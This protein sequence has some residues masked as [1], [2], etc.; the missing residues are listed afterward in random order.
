M[1]IGTV[2]EDWAVESMAGDIFLLGTHSWQIRRIEAGVVR[3]RDAGDAPPTVPFWLGEAPARTAEL[4]EEVSELRAPRRRASSPPAIP[5]AHAP[6]CST[7]AGIEH[8][9]RD[10]ARRLPGGRPRGARRDADAASSSCSSGS[11]TRP[12]ACSWSSTRPTAGASTGRSGWRCARS[13]AAR[14]TSSS[15]RPRPTTPSCCRSARTTASRSTRCRATC[16]SRGIED[17]LEHAILDAPMF[18]AR[19]RWNLNRS[20]IVLRFRGGRR[21]PPPIQRMEADDLMAAVFPQ[22]AAC[23]DNA[24]GPDRDPRP[25]DRAPDDRRHAARGARRRRPARRCSSAIE[26]GE[27]TVALRRH[28]RAVGARARD[29]H[30]AAVRV[31][32]RRGV[33]EPPHQRGHL[34]RG[35]AGRPRVDRRARSRSHRA[36]A[37]RDHARAGDR[38]RPPRPAVLA[39]HHPR[40]RR[41]ARAVG[42]ARRARPRPGRVQ[43]DGDEL[44]VRHRAR[45]TTPERAIAGDDDAVAAVV[46][47]HLEIAGITTVDALAHVDHRLARG[48][49]PR[50]SRCSSTRASRS[51]AL[52]R[53]PRRTPS[54]SRAGSSPA[55]TP[56]RGASA[57]SASSPPPPQD[58]MRFLLR[59]QHV[60]PGT[61]LAG[62]SGLADG[63]RPAPGLR[64]GGGRV[65]ARAAGSPAAPLRPGL[66]STGS[67]TTAR[68]AGCGSPREPRDDADVARRARRRRRRRSRSCSATTCAGCSTASRGGADPA[69]PDGRRR[70]PRSSRCCASA[71]ACFAAELGEATAGCPKTSSARCGTASP[72]ACSPP[73][74]SARSGPASQRQ[75][76]QRG[77]SA[78]ARLSRARCAARGA[79]PGGRAAG[80]WS[81][82]ARRRRRRRPPIA[83]SSP[84]PSPSCCST[85]G[86][87]CSAT[88]RCASRSGSR[89]AT[90]SGRC[91]GSKTA[92]SCAAAAS[93]PASAASSTRSRRRPSSSRT[94]AS[95]PAPASGSS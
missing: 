93:S 4:S 18:Q 71:G 84:R 67:A 7:T 37:R 66:R 22:A 73:T 30:R 17:T 19:W 14:S 49:V 82:R 13:S 58:F 78:G 75:R 5:T 64:G 90:S 15:R 16:S 29:P 76:R 24:V 45:S 88:S 57:A 60:A 55:C 92:G 79:P 81:L 8:G 31:P 95:C 85:A 74:A 25:R 53:R 36:G 2:N 50:A 9:G 32:R 21:N 91:A 38:R 28:H 1:F 94:C 33:P 65:G 35:L 61:Q 44:L 89:G 52:H 59:W 40:P 48:R 11:S 80:R 39:R 87:S 72:A 42:R 68:S 77:P 41:V 86:A 20:L 3:V 70:P 63:D 10:D 23:Q 51:R 54:G 62:D 56:T 47:G 27:V 6:G 12:A 83:R 26:A 34:R 46:R 43:H 69:E